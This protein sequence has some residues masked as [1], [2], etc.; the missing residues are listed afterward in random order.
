MNQHHQTTGILPTAYSRSGNTLSV[1][2]AG[3]R[4]PYTL[5][6]LELTD[7]RLV[8]RYELLYNSLPNIRTDSNY[9]R[10]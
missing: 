3:G 9:S 6:I 5:T 8:V 2:P 1:K 7:R 10:Q 4:T